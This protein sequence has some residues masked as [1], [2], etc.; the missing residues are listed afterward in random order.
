ME[1]FL[2]FFLL[3]IFVPIKV[4][5]RKDK[6]M[7]SREK[8]P[9]TQKSEK[10][11]AVGSQLTELSLVESCFVLVLDRPC[12]KERSRVSSR[13]PV[14]EPS[15]ACNLQQTHKFNLPPTLYK[16]TISSFLVV[17]S[18]STPFPSLDRHNG[19][20]PS[21]ASHCWRWCLW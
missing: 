5:K 21:E 9:I 20:N 10:T 4:I 13:E 11:L 15:Q 3:S 16:H 6:S 17:K 1:K 19:G 18:L 12:H 7:T 14:A 2:H 8:N